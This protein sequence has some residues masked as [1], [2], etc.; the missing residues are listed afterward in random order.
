MPVGNLKRGFNRLFLVLMFL[1][2]LLCLLLP[3]WER[4]KFVDNW[5]STY[6]KQESDCDTDTC[7]Q[8]MENSVNRILTENTLRKWYAEGW[9]YVLIFGLGVP[10]VAYD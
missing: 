7:R 3:L 4:N 6:A 9:P 8:S 1:W 2:F 5:L 10:P